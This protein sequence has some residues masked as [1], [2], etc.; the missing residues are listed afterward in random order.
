[1][2]PILMKQSLWWWQRIASSIVSPTPTSW[3]L[4]ARQKSTSTVTTQRQ[5]SLMNKR[6][7][8]DGEN[9]TSAAKWDS[10]PT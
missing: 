3:N 2:L 5:A 1:M 8:G 6:M 4:D 10:Q 9:S 7:N